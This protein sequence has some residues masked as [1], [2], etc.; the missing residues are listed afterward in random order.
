MSALSQDQSAGRSAFPLWQRAA[1]FSIA[2]FVCAQLGSYLSVRGGTYVSFWLPGGLYVAALLLNPTRDWVWLIL[3]GF[4]AN[5][6]FDLLRGTSLAPIIFFY[7]ANTI[8]SVVGA[9]LVRR[10]VEKRPAMSSLKEYFGLLGFAAV[11]SAGLGAL[12]GATTLVAFGFSNAFWHSLKVWW[13]S[14]GMAVLVLSPFVLAWF[15]WTGRKPSRLPMPRLVEAVLLVLGLVAVNW[16]IMM[17]GGGILSPYKAW[18]I[19]FLLWAGLRFSVRGATA[20]TLITALPT[21]FLTMQYQRGL[22][23]AEIASGEYVFILQTVLA[24]GSLVSLIPALVLNERDLTLASLRDSEEKFSKAFQSS[25]AAMVITRVQ[26]GLIIDTN[27][28]LEKTFG[29]TR[30][31]MLGKTTLG[32]HAWPDPEQRARMIER[33]RKD[34]EV[35]NEE[36]IMRGK[37]GRDLSLQ[38]SGVAVEIGGET[39]LLSVLVD[40]TARKQAEEALRRNELLFRAIVSDQTEMIVRWKPDGTR[41]FV[42]QAYCRIFGGRPEDHLG[43]SFF[44]LIA[45]EHREVIHQKILKLTPENPLATT[46]HRSLTSGGKSLWQEWTDRAIFDEAGRL[47]ELQSTGR[48]ITERKEAE[49]S[50]RAAQER[51]LRAREEFGHLLL[52][53]Q[54]KER[55]RLANE[56]HDSLGQNLSIIKNRLHLTRRI[57]GTTEEII[58][59]IDALER[60]TEEAIAETRNLARNLRPPHI[61]Q[62]GLSDSLKGLILEVSSSTD[63]HIERRVENVDDVLK[64][65]AATHVYRIVQ[66]ALN[67]LVKHSKA[68]QAA[69]TLER[70]IRS[71]RVLIQDD[72]VGFEVPR[73][74]ANGGLGLTSLDE[75]ARMLGGWMRIES[76]PRRGTRLEF[77]I[78]IRETPDETPEED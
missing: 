55:M 4:P 72:G 10:F 51:E 68:T 70:D 11:L 6:L 33:I 74:R 12:I 19:P 64:G 5:L 66:E 17:E 25:P 7:L 76:A 1:L 41:T 77:H 45:P 53:A 36:L 57:P 78:P 24:V 31:E 35:L 54:E 27:P 50:L 75:R 60:V 32:L 30:E 59:N 52:N 21:S 58:S 37:D 14:T 15:S 42:N 40:L 43:T 62:I 49:E 71:V 63:I 3:A 22:T 56:L 69:V 28:A 44:P 61:D 34:G 16:Y 29:F 46:I 13:G 67:N 39:V 23:P 65:E 73:S 20:A 18:L 38:Y 47:V 8:Q 9:T 2:Y 26:D 48:D